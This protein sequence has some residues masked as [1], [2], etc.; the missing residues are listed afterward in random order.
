M[1]RRRSAFQGRSSL[2]EVGGESE[3]F[4]CRSVCRGCVCLWVVAT[5]FDIQWKEERTNEMMMRLRSKR[6][7]GVFEEGEESKHRRKGPE[8][9]SAL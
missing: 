3:W 8:M 2:G 1:G 9:V 5:V 6:M 7:M 4:V